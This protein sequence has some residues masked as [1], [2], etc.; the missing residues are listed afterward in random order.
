[1]APISQSIL[2]SMPEEIEPEEEGA[3]PFLDLDKLRSDANRVVQVR[4]TVAKIQQKK[5]GATEDVAA[6]LSATDLSSRQLCLKEL[7]GALPRFGALIAA[8]IPQAPLIDPTLLRQI[9]QVVPTIAA[10]N[11]ALKSLGT[12]VFP[13]PLIN[14]TLLRQISQVVPTIAASNLALKSLG[15]AVFPGPLIDPALQRQ[16]SKLGALIDSALRRQMSKLGPLI[17][18]ALWRQMSQFGQTLAALNSVLNNQ[19]AESLSLWLREYSRSIRIAFP[20]PDPLLSDI[21]NA[22]DKDPSAAERLAL[23]ISWQPDQWQRE[24]IRLKSRFEG[25]SPDEVRKKGN[26]IPNYTGQRVKVSG[27]LLCCRGWVG[28]VVSG[29][30]LRLRFRLL[31]WR[32]DLE[33]LGCLRS[34][35]AMSSS[36]TKFISTLDGIRKQNVVFPSWFVTAKSPAL[37][38]SIPIKASTPVGSC[39]PAAS[40]PTTWTLFG[41]T[42]LTRYT[43]TSRVGPPAVSTSVNVV[44]IKPRA[45]V[46]WES[47]AL[48]LAPVSHRAWNVCA[49][50]LVVGLLGSHA[51]E[52][53]HEV[54]SRDMCPPLL[55]AV[56][57]V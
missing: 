41:N 13:A 4:R 16:M 30:F 23:R 50:G 55:R 47:M 35:L 14:P 57:L 38:M 25:S 44:L 26:Y 34:K 2:A 1:M 43:G 12:A 46:T 3:R 48:R 5:Q 54:K 6:E 42:M 32:F 52:I 21:I 40:T 37:I 8:K 27:A 18:S 11:L 15:T 45:W 29:Y 17:D 53:V 51:S 28:V 33:G 20:P 49:T 22:L 31:C 56:K 7:A 19:V 24:C 36:N 39:R 9:S 10:A